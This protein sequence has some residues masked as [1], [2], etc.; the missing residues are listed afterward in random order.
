MQGGGGG[1]SSRLRRRAK[2]AAGAYASG[3]DASPVRR[4]IWLSCERWIINDWNRL[5]LYVWQGAYLSTYPTYIF[6]FQPPTTIFPSLPC[7]TFSFLI[8]TLTRAGFHALWPPERVL[9]RETRRLRYIV[10][11]LRPSSSESIS[12]LCS[13]RLSQCNYYSTQG[14][15]AWCFHLFCTAVLQISAYAQIDV[16]LY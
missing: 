5:T 13:S 12:I 8:A 3:A 9:C 4:T 10:L 15:A 2:L 16:P 6:S 1:S 14:A 7:F 11:L